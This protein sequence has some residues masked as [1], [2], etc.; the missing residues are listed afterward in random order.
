MALFLSMDEVEV[1]SSEPQEATARR[2]LSKELAMHEVEVATG[3]PERISSPDTNQLV[4]DEV[5]VSCERNSPHAPPEVLV[6]S[7][8]EVQSC[9]SQQRKRAANNESATVVRGRGV[10]KA[11]LPEVEGGREETEADRTLG[12]NFASKPLSQ[13]AVFSCF[14]LQ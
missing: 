4:M 7:E 13:S 8:V 14:V 11:K 2:T 6:M 5:E 1:E 10:E 9:A 12:K 3:E